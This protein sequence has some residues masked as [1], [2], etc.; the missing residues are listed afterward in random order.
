MEEKDL[1]VML[2]EVREIMSQLSADDRGRFILYLRS[3]FL[4]NKGNQ[5]PDVY[6]CR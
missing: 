2:E 5:Y 4:E 3:L 6:T 1:T